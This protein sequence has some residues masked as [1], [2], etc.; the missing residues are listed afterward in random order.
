MRGNSIVVVLITG[1]A[2]LLFSSWPA[3]GSGKGESE[4]VK[5]DVHGGTCC[6]TL[7]G[8]KVTLN[9]TPKPVKAMH[10][11]DF[12]VTFAGEQPVIDPYIDLTMEGMNMGRN[13]VMLKPR[14][15]SLYQG[16][17]VIVRCPSG[18]RTWKARITAPDLGSV[19]FVFDVIY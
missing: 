7:D 13:R 5:C 19:E 1:M 6:S 11:L 10:H 17:G 12:T 18:R 14:G 15:D 3:A 4:A 9:I 16:K 2:L 8:T